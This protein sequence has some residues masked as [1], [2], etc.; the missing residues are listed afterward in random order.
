MRVTYNPEPS[1]PK[2]PVRALHLSVGVVELVGGATTIKV[3]HP[4]FCHAVSMDDFFLN[5]CELVI[6]RQPPKRPTCSFR[7]RSHI[8]TFVLVQGHI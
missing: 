3:V 1:L 2:L 8:R 5:Y 6:G 4:L 7:S